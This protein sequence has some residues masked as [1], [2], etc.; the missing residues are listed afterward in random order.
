MSTN[1]P[2]IVAEVLELVHKFWEIVKFSALQKL[3]C[4]KQFKE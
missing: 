1:K 4:G 2:S 3:H